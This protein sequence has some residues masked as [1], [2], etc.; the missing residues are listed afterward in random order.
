MSTVLPE[1]PAPNDVRLR[2][3]FRFDYPGSDIILRS[4]DSHNFR[5]PKLYIVNN[6]PVLREV[7]GYRTPL[8]TPESGAILHRLFTFVFPDTPV[9]SSTTEDI[10]EFLAVVQKYQMDYGGS[11]TG[12]RFFCRPDVRNDSEPKMNSRVGRR[13]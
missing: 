2:R 12:S 11:L 10:M 9:L 3:D 13:I 5:V 6:S 1:T 8:G 4:S 7:L